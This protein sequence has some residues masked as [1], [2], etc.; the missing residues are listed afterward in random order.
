LSC[1]GKKAKWFS[2]IEKKML[3]TQTSREIHNHSKINGYNTQA[4]KIKW[5]KLSEDRRK[6]E[7]II[8]GPKN[9]QQFSKIIKKKKGKA[10]VEHWLM[11]KEEGKTV[12]ELSKCTGYEIR[13]E[14]TRDSCEKWIKRKQSIKA[15]PESLVEKNNNR[16]NAT[17][18]QLLEN[19]TIEEWK[20]EER[21]LVEL[22]QIEELEIELIKKQRLNEAIMSQL[23][24]R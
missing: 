2:E 23:I 11:H 20:K 4:L 22:K 3:I 6:R 15:I 12:T 24:K 21:N 14:Q 10:L 9:N 16:I 17:L 19:R 8:Y 5:T 13:S 18:E 1:K 7:W